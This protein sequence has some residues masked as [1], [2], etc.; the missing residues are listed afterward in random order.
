VFVSSESV[1]TPKRYSELRQQYPRGQVVTFSAP[2][3]PAGGMAVL[4]YRAWNQGGGFFSL[5][6]NDSRWAIQAWKDWVE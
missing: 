1:G 5:L 4:Y 2:I 3:Y 6:R